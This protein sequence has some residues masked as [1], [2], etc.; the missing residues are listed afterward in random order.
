MKGNQGYG[1]KVGAFLCNPNRL[2]LRKESNFLYR[3]KE[4]IQNLANQSPL[5][6]A[7][8]FIL[9]RKE[10]SDSNSLIDWDFGINRNDFSDT[11]SSQTSDLLPEVNANYDS[12]EQEN[13]RKT[14]I[15]DTIVDT[16]VKKN[17]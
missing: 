14:F 17:K 12:Y 10:R 16:P 3:Q 5:V 9:P 4:S 2:T 1:L 15:S 7:S 8:K 6:E 13:D 11:N